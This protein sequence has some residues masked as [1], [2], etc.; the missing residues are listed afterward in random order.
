[1]ATEP[2]DFVETWSVLKKTVEGIFTLGYLTPTAFEK[3]CGHVKSLCKANPTLAFQMYDETKMLLEAHVNSLLI[4][5]KEK[6]EEGILTVYYTLWKQ[7]RRGVDKLDNLY[8]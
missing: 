4:Q 5:V 1:M 8:L 2:V 3:G 6:R 7:Y